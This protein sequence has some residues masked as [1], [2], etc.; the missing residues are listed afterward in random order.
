M[1]IPLALLAGPLLAAAPEADP[2]DAHPPVADPPLCVYPHHDHRRAPAGDPLAL[3]AIGE[4]EPNDSLAQAQ[5]LPLGDGPNEDNAVDVQGEISP[6]DQRDFFS[7]ILEQGDTLGVAVVSPS[8]FDSLV[9]LYDPDGEPIKENDILN[10]LGSLLPA[11]SPL[12]SAV[13]Q[14]DSNLTFVAPAAG[15]YAIEVAPFVSGDGGT[16]TLEARRA[17]P[18]FETLSPPATQIIFVDFDGAT[19]NAPALFGAGNNP[20]NLAP[21]ST[22]LFNWDLSSGDLDP[23]IDE[24]LAVIEARLNETAALSPNFAFEIRNS[25]DDP[26]PFGE[27]NV[28]RLI[29]GG[30]QFQL[31]IGTIGIASAIDPGNFSGEDT[32]VVLLDTLG[33]SSDFSVNS[34]PLAPGFTKVQAVAR[35]LGNVAAHEAGHYLGGFHTDPDTPARNIMDAGAL[36]SVRRSIFGL[37]PDL[38]FATADDDTTSFLPDL[39]FA[40]EGYRGEQRCDIRVSWALQSLLSSACPEDLDGDGVRGPTDLAILLGSWGA[41]F[42]S[43]DFNGDMVVDAFDLAVLLGAWGPC[44]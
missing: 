21:L 12:P 22:F 39:Y 11:D 40:D 3:L 42:P 25:R 29:I 13:F 38:T 26:D 4:N 14:F 23:L 1:L 24:T 9:R 33:S 35:A 41:D 20:A 30:N 16:Y 8:G 44:P 15:A 18:K 27:P 10:G 32:A 28:S 17:R 37:G 7:V 6:A 31:G 19:I 2:A 5:L 43:A 34:Y 36:T